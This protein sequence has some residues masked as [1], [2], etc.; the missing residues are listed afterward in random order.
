MWIP[1]TF[2]GG[3]VVWDKKS[4]SFWHVKLLSDYNWH[5]SSSTRQQQAEAWG[6][7]LLIHPW[8]LLKKN[9]SGWHLKLLFSR[10]CAMKSLKTNPK[11]RG[12]YCIPESCVGRG[13]PVASLLRDGRS[14]T[15]AVTSSYT[16]V[17][18]LRQMGIGMCLILD[19][20][21]SALEFCVSH[22]LH[23]PS[24]CVARLSW[25]QPG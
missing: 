13:P 20:P 7:S 6:S 21:L 2:L 17:L 9:K 10:R 3:A 12:P 23:G 8:N 14:N 25:A 22:V 15:A 11:P 4:S 19:G 5:Q 1:V 16:L 24:S 18:R